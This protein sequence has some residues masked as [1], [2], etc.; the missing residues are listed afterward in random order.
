[1]EQLINTLKT[2]TFEKVISTLLLLVVCLI[3][4]RIISKIVEKAVDNPKVEPRMR[5]FI[6]GAIKALLYIL[7]ALI[8]ADS[9]G[10]PITSLVALFSVFSLAISLAVQDVLANVAGGMVILFAKPFVIG[11]YVET[12]ACSGTVVAIDLIHT[13]FDTPDGQ[14][15]MMPN[16][17]LADSKITNYTQLG[18]RRV[19]HVI[20]ASYDDPAQNVRKSCL[21]AV[22]MTDKVLADPAPVVVVSNYGSSSIEYHVRCWTN[23]DDYW[24]VHFALMENIKT[25][26]D[27]DGVTMTYDHLNV[28]VVEK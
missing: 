17:T 14:R 25:A 27:Q 16:S 15:V 2:F 21:K 28:H 9:I 20:T 26:F 7:A 5:K 12:D 11:D 1:M 22:A 23:V 18:T 13:K 8:L 19:D 24:D 10:I 6:G 3:V 4:I